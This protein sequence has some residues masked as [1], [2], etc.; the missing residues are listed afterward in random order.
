M[1][2]KKI[3]RINTNCI[4]WD[5]R[6]EVFN[7]EDA[8]PL[9]VADMDFQAPPEIISALHQRVEHGIFG[10]SFAP[11]SLYQAVVNWNKTRH[12]WTIEKDD[13]I[14]T[15]NVLAPI[16]I[17]LRILSKEK[18]NIIM[19]SPIYFPFFQIVERINRNPIFSNMLIKDNKYVVDFTAFE[20][21]IIKEKP[22]VL[23]FCNP[24]NPSGRVWDKTELSKIIELCQKHNVK[25]ISDEI[26]KD[27]VFLDSSYT[28]LLSVANTY[29]DSVFCVSAPTKSFN[30]AGIK[31]AYTIITN[32]QVASEFQKISKELNQPSPNIFGMVAMEA[33]YNHCADWIDELCGYLQTNYQLVQTE[34]Q[35]TKFNCLTCEGTYLL[36]IDYSQYNITEIEFYQLLY[37]NGIGVQQ[38]SQFGKMGTNYFRM[39]VATQRSNLK[40]ALTKLKELFKDR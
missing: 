38:G 20:Q 25:I 9:W 27:L 8:I 29:Q 11:Q 40:E 36:W 23:I 26:H 2:N 12:N 6:K 21:Q 4:K 7:N 39:N 37:Q 16:N 10:Y 5:Q 17:L 1:F 18:D 28:P 22:A 19:L 33:A 24:H 30:L 14:F 35:D 3:S 13:I 34:L 32:K 15:T 31:I